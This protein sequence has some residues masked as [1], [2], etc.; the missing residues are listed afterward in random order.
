[1]F[2]V[3]RVSRFVLIYSHF[4]QSNAVFRVRRRRQCKL[5]EIEQLRLS[6]NKP[7]SYGAQQAAANVHGGGGGGSSAV[8]VD[9]VFIPSLQR[10]A[11]LIPEFTL[12]AIFRR[13]H[14]FTERF[15]Q[16]A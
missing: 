15:R 2:P 16:L 3:D 4:N 9:L 1:M 6:P 10:R 8:L 12:T 11:F 7:K 14:V 13:G 5:D